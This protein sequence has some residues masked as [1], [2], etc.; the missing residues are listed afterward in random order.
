MLFGLLKNLIQKN[1]M[2]MKSNDT[3]IKHILIDAFSK[4][5]LYGNEFTK[6]GVTFFEVHHGFKY[7][8]VNVLF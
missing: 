5:E 2:K 1:G 3:R 7:G 6:K 4:E 8:Y